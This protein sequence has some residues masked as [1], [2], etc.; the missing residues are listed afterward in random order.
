MKTVLTLTLAPVLAICA[1]AT[2][3]QSA[4]PEAL[5]AAITYNII[6][7]VDFPQDSPADPV[8]L[9]VARGAAA[10][11]ELAALGGQRIGNRAIQFRPVEPDGTAGCDV[12]YLGQASAGDIVKSRRRGAITVGEGPSFIGAGGTI[13][14]VRTGNQVRFEV[15]LKASRDA[16]FSI[17]SRL[18][19][20]AAR[21]QQ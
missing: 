10:S 4:G 16:G 12:V 21:I 18:L 8:Q 14:L 17:S 13:G 9:C 2:Q 11:R 19:R 15:N 3:A 6:R 1:S 20:L 5:K 7:F